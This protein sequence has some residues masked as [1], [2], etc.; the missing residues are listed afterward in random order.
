MEK[1]IIELNDVKKVLV[2]LS[3][4][5][6]CCACN[7]QND[8]ESSPEII[9]PSDE[10]IEA[11]PVG[12]VYSDD[13]SANRGPTAIMESEEAYFYDYGWQF[14]PDEAE[15]GVPII[16]AATDLSLHRL[17]RYDKKSGESS[18]L[19]SQP[20]C[21]HESDGNCVAVNDNIEVIGS[22]LYE[23]NIYIYGIEH[24]DTQINYKLYKVGLS[25]SSIKTVATILSA[26]NPEE[27]EYDILPAH[28]AH[29]DNY[30]GFI[31]HRGCAYIPYYLSVGK[32]IVAELAG[33]GLMKVDINT[34]EMQKLTEMT[35]PN[36]PF[37]CDLYGIDD[38]V[39]TRL[40]GRSDYKE[41]R[42]R[43]T[44]EEWEDSKLYIC[45][46]G[47]YMF[48]VGA[49]QEPNGTYQLH[50]FT[51]RMEDEEL[52][53]D[54]SFDVNA[55]IDELCGGIKRGVLCY[56]EKLFFFCESRIIA[57]SVAEDDFG[58]KIIDQAI[59]LPYGKEDYYNYKMYGYIDNNE[60]I[61]YRITNGTV[62]RVMV[63]PIAGESI[64]MDVVE[65]RYKPYIVDGCSI[66]DM[67]RGE[68]E[69]TECFEYTLGKN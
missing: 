4:A 14:V 66:D 45:G 35:S 16:Y 46:S 37:P 62:Y 50:V 52:I 42:Y 8:T 11:I 26:D 56:D 36:D 5:L 64:R 19:C 1:P 41:R 6:M 39:Y 27:K 65:G 60:T 59:I 10:P 3:I 53:Q 55:E 17:C 49:V 22:I 21:R 32:G 67:L 40:I 34:G 68:F 58:S 61:R 63:N 51:Y 18:F 48:N 33:G 54:L 44:R 24:V 12:S 28:V 25:G 43:I 57:Y 38:Y 47:E 23:E 20:D 2:I 31:I 15:N 13:D 7:A 30:T 29:I 9:T 69:F